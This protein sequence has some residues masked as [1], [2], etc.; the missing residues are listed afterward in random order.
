MKLISWNVNGIR[1]ATRKGLPEFVEKE[2]ADVYCFQEIKAKEDQIPEEIQELSYHKFFHPAERPGYAGT[3][4]FSKDKPIRVI[5]GIGSE[6]IDKEGRVLTLEFDNFYM[7][8][9]YFPQ[10]SRDLSR[11]GFKVNFNKNFHDFCKRLD[12]PVVI[13]SDFNV[14][15]TE[16]DL[17]NPRANVGNAG[18]TEEE[19]E[20]FTNF[21]ADGHIDTFRSFVLEGHHYTW[22]PY[23]FGARERNIGW[24]IDYFV[25]SKE[26]H[27]QVKS[28]EILRHVYGSDHCPI[29]LVLGRF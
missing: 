12:K 4:I 18:F 17:R 10:S 16:I 23:A 13:A 29:C 20:W 28:S 7:I 6:E 3:A 21:L 22:W 1:A 11:L 15:H 24:R 14:A 27:G 2:G 8:N 26:L 25:V 19:R 5:K 9:A